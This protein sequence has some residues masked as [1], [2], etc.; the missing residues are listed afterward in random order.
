[1]PSFKPRFKARLDKGGKLGVRCRARAARRRRAGS[2][3]SAIT[4][5]GYAEQACVVGVPD[6]RADRD[7]AGDAVPR[8]C[9]AHRQAQ[10]SGSTCC[11]VRRSST[12]INVRDS[13]EARVRTR[14]LS[15]LLWVLGLGSLL[16]CRRRGRAALVRADV[17]GELPAARARRAS[18]PRS[19]SSTSATSPARKLAL[20]CGYVGTALMVLSM[21]YPLR[22]R[23]GWFQRTREPVLARRAPDDRHRRAAVHRAALRAAADHV[24]LDPVLEHESPSW[25]RACSAATST[26]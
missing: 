20:T 12:G 2:R 6:R 8:A 5:P 9:R 23:F 15:V 25:S 17:V 1:M 4:A 14:K 3:T 11:R 10:A 7:R 19:R 22:R 13:G 16:G 24:G 21:A 18:S 26:R